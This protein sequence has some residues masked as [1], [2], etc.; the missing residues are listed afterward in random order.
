ME[1]E[2]TCDCSIAG[3]KSAEDLIR[4][5]INWVNVKKAEEFQDVTTLID[6]ATAEELVA[7]LNL[8]AQKVGE[9]CKC[10]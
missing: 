8:L 4:D 1:E 3:S 2:K 10:D 6:P 5:L 7:K 9:I